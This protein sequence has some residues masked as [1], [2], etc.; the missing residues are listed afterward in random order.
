MLELTNQL[1]ARFIALLTTLLFP[2]SNIIRVLYIIPKKSITFVLT[3]LATL[4]IRTASQGGSFAFIAFPLK[5][6]SLLKVHFNMC[7]EGFSFCRK[8]YYL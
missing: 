7:L 1:Y 5:Y 8:K 6:I 4:P 3:V 2:V